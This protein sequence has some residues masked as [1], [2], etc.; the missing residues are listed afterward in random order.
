MSQSKLNPLSMYKKERRTLRS[1]LE[2][3]FRVVYGSG[4]ILTTHGK[5]VYCSNLFMKL[6]QT[7]L[8]LLSLCPDPDDKDFQFSRIDLSSTAALS[9]VVM[10]TFVAWFHFGF[11]ECSEDEFRTRQLLLFWRDFRVRAKVFAPFENGGVDEYS[12]FHSAD[13]KMR[14]GENEFWMSLPE[15]TRDHLLRKNN[16]LHS[17]D[18]VLTRAGF[19]AEECRAIYA[20]FS[21]HTHCDSVAFMRVGENDRG[22]GF[23]NDADL[24]GLVWCLGTSTPFLSFATKKTNEFF[25]DALSRANKVKGFNPFDIRIPPRPWAGISFDDL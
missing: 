4:D 1:E 10:D 23:S 13:L 2:K 25:K 22:Q 15:K 6:C 7:S 21:A 12:D 16:T 24:S 19:D 8:S 20:Y 3:A 14:L 11:E 17:P 5:Q 18:E 9:R